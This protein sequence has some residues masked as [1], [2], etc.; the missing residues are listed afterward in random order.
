MK[1]AASIPLPAAEVYRAILDPMILAAWWDIDYATTGPSPLHVFEVEFPRD[2]SPCRFFGFITEREPNLSVTIE[3]VKTEKVPIGN[4]FIR[5]TPT[6]EGC[7]LEIEW[8]EE[9]LDRLAEAFLDPSGH[10]RLGLV[11]DQFPLLLPSNG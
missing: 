8:E 3:I 5:L 4:L 6:E 2:L 7:Q 9:R 11:L 1:Q 10:V